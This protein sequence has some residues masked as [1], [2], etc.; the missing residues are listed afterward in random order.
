MKKYVFAL[1]S[2]LF[3]FSLSMHAAGK[4]QEKCRVVFSV[5]IHCD[6][7]VAKIEKNIAFEKGVRDLLIDKE[8]E[9]VTVVYNPDKTDVETLKR[10]FAKIGKPVKAVESVA[11]AK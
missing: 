10:A 3:V 2:F 6:A 8:K 4:K 7:C 5:E 1:L 11:D 9:T